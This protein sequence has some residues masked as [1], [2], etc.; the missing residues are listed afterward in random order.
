MAVADF[1]ASLHPSTQMTRLIFLSPPSP[2]QE[3]MFQTSTNQ[4]TKLPQKSVNLRLSKTSS[5]STSAKGS[6]FSALPSPC[7]DNRSST[8]LF[9]NH[10]DHQDVK[11]HHKAKLRKHIS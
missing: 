7:V 8:P 3:H 6:N 4:T 11:R 2:S 9:F 1:G 5:H 10:K